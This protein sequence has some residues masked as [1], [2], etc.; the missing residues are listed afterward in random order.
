[1]SAL[2]RLLREISAADRAVSLDE[3]ARR[4]GV[5]RDEAD[6]MVG[7]WVRK[8]RLAVTDLATACPTGG[9]AGCAFATA[10]RR[11]AT[12][13]R[14]TGRGRGTGGAGNGAPGGGRGGP[15]GSGAGGG[16]GCHKPPGG[17]ALLAIT[18]RRP[19]EERA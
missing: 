5:S 3:I 16:P 12:G 6:A 11:A 13:D 10:A 17:P 2:R 8:G 14:G 1:M 4:V 19:G 9:C 7:Y 15:G 18:V